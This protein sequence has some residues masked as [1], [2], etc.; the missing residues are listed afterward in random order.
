MSRYIA[1]FIGLSMGPSSQAF[2][3]EANLFGKICGLESPSNGWALGSG[4]LKGHAYPPK[5]M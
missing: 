5:K 1:M 4:L 2:F 3:V